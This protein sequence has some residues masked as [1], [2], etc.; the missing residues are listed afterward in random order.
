MKGT[1]DVVIIGAGV[2]GCGTAY[3]L[4]QMDKKDVVV[5][6]MDQAGSGSS[7]KSASMLSLQYC[8][9]RIKETSP[10]QLEDLLKFL[11]GSSI[12]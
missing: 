2:I 1:A 5:V 8:E 11:D 10:H 7:G 6:E 4:A 3:H 9:E 12:I